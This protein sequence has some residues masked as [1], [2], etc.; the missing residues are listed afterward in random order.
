[1]PNV[2][3][4]PVD[5]EQLAEV[6]NF[7][8]FELGGASAPPA[9][10]AFTPAEIARQRTHPLTSTSLIDTR[11]RVVE[12]IERKCGVSRKMLDPAAGV[13]LNTGNR[14]GQN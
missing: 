13:T 8:V 10:S 14:R 12:G 9:A 5:D 7:V 4:A 1:L 11:A 3:A 2:T 6:M